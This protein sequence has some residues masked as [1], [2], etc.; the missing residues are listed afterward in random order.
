MIYEPDSICRRNA[1]GALEIAFADTRRRAAAIRGGSGLFASSE[2]AAEI[3]ALLAHALACGLPSQF[4]ALIRGCDAFGYEHEVWFQED[5][6]NPWVLKATYTDTFGHLPDGTLCLP[7]QYFERLLL[8]NEIFGD[9]IRLEGI[10]PGAIHSCRVITSQPAVHGRFA[11]S[12]EVTSFFQERGF[13]AVKRGR[14]LLWWRSA[15][16]IL[17]A[18]TH[19]GNILVTESGAFAAIDVPVMRV[20]GFF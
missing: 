17:C 6:A 7:S 14:R 18:D 2:L 15:D 12:E 8:Q 1:P 5:E 4:E 20:S 10:V 13:E 9:D 19:G 3:E 16:N 11:T